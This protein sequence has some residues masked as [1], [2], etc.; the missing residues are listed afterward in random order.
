[1]Q[2]RETVGIVGGGAA[3]MTAAIFAARQGAEVTL[4]EANDRLGKKILSTGNGKCNLSNRVL[5]TE[6]YYTSEPERLGRFLERFG[7]KDTIDFFGSLGLLVREKNGYLYPLSEQASSVLDVLRFQI[8]RE[9]RIQV[10]YRCRVEEIR[11][12]RGAE[13]RLRAGEE[14]FS[15]DRVILACGGKAAPKTGS[16]GGGYRLA[17]QLGHELTPVVPAL[18]QLRCREEWLKSVAGVRAEA[19]LAMEDG[20]GRIQRERGELQLTDYG[21]SGIPVFQLSRQAGYILRKQKEI[22]VCIDFLPDEPREGFAER[23][24]SAR[25]FQGRDE[26]AEEYFTG[27]LN[28]KLMTLMIKLAGMRSS[29]PVRQA[30]KRKVARVYELC[31]KLPVWVIGTN[32]FENA[33]ICAG[34]VPLSQVTDQLESVKAA[35]VYFAGELLDVDGRCGGYNLQWAWCSGAL[36]AVGAIQGAEG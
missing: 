21:I 26:T 3:G 35:G 4:L 31:R 14:W 23:M 20:E 25:P 5:G 1:M 32:G 8:E 22:R 33:Q 28:K 27:M 36:A 10:R 7:V 6:Q 17:R 24:M 30:E 29:D 9:P 34:G 2:K 11:C 16:D 15:F 12:L 18:V 13:I 19:E